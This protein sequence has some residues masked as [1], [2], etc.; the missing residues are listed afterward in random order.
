[1]KYRVVAAVLVAVVALAAVGASLAVVETSGPSGIPLATGTGYSSRGGRPPKGCFGDGARLIAKPQVVRAGNVVVLDLATSEHASR[2]AERSIETGD[3]GD[4]DG[5]DGG[6][7]R[8]LYLVSTWPVGSKKTSEDFPAKSD[9]AIAGVGIGDG[10]LRAEVPDVAAGVY[11]FRLQYAVL[12]D[13]FTTPLKVGK[14]QF[15]VDVTVRP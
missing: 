12:P 13:G 6:S 14:Y 5:L 7:W 11:R 8:W 2:V 10:G 3:F 9:A 1:M 15:C 4:F